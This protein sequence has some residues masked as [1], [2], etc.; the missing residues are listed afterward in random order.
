M[1]K[2]INLTKLETA[3]MLKA[4]FGQVVRGWFEQPERAERCRSV[5]H[6]GILTQPKIHQKEI[7]PADKVL[8]T[9]SAT[10]TV[11]TN[12]GSVGIQFALRKMD[13]PGS[14]LPAYWSWCGGMVPVDDW[15]YMFQISS[16]SFCEN[17]R[18][19]VIDSDE[20]WDDL[21]SLIEGI[22]ESIESM[23]DALYNKRSER[24]L[25]G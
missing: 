13:R 7:T 9:R 3:S 5:W 4:G 22:N 11:E 2:L 19:L 21:N 18:V 12:I 16:Y 17:N 10:L 23:V 8:W 25:N 14:Y 24:L 6:R 1:T 15:Y 20:P